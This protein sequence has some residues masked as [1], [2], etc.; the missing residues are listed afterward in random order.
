MKRFLSLV[1]I[2]IVLVVGCEMPSNDLYIPYEGERNDFTNTSFDKDGWESDEQSVNFNLDSEGLTVDEE[3]R[4][5]V[6]KGINSNGMKISFRS[7]DLE[8]WATHGD[9]SNLVSSKYVA[10]EMIDNQDDL[11]NVS[12]EIKFSDTAHNVVF[13][14]NNVKL[15]D[16]YVIP[17]I[18]VNAVYDV[19]RLDIGGG[20]LTFSKNANHINVRKANDDGI[21][22]RLEGNSIILIDNTILTESCYITSNMMDNVKNFDFGIDNEFL[23]YFISNNG[24]FR[25]DMNGAL[26]I[27]FNPIEFHKKANPT[28]LKIKVKWDMDSIFSAIENDVYILN[29]NADGT[30]YDFDIE[31]EIN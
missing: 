10:W 2:L 26:F 7:S 3:T 16:E 28:K 17:K 24:N 1:V 13:M 4:R 15:G 14:P 19:V 9:F 5:G 29:D 20:D 31:I 27:P 18:D 30:P 6:N 8:M 22:A 23:Q 21:G 11:L 25:I 12:S